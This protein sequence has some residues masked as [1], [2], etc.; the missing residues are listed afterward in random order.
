MLSL[1]EIQNR[2]AEVFQ[3]VIQNMPSG[4]GNKSLRLNFS[5]VRYRSS[6]EMVKDVQSN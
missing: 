5:Q 1:S 2:I 4:T 6:G 3:K